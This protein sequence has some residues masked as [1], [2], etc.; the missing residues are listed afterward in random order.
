MLEM[1]GSAEFGLDFFLSDNE[2]QEKMFLILS[3][4]CL[5]DFANMFV[6]KAKHNRDLMF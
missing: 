5:I 6:F 4:L 3:F 2:E 1:L